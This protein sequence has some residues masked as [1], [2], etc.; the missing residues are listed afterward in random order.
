MG[1]RMKKIVMVVIGLILGALCPVLPQVGTELVDFNHCNIDAASQLPDSFSIASEPPSCATLETSRKEYQEG[2]PVDI[3]FTNGCQTSIHLDTSPSWTIKDKDGN[4]ICDDPTVIFIVTEIRPSEEKTWMWYQK[5][6]IGK[7]VGLGTYTFFLYAREGTYT[8]TFEIIPAPPQCAMVTTNQEAYQLGEPVEI[9]FTNNC[10][11]SLRY[12]NEPPWVVKDRQGQVVFPEFVF[13]PIV[14]VPPGEQVTWTWDQKNKNQEQVPPD[15]YSIELRTEE[16][17]YKTTFEIVQFL[18]CS[19]LETS[20]K[21]YQKGEPVEILFTNNCDAFINLPSDPPWVISDTQGNIVFPLNVLPVEINIP[22]DGQK[23]WTWDQKNNAKIPKQVSAGTYNV[24]LTSLEGAYYKTTFKIVESLDC[25]VLETDKKIYQVGVP[26]EILFTNNCQTT[27]SLPSEPP[28]VITD[29]HGDIVFPAAVLYMIVEVSPGEQKMWTWNQKDT[30][31]KQ[32]SAGTYTIELTSTEGAYYRTTFEIVEASDCAL[33]ETGTKVYQKGVPVEILFTNNCQAIINLPSDP[34]WVISDS[35]G[36]VVYPGTVL[37]VLVEVQPGG[38][39]TW[40]WDQKTKDKVPKQVPAGTYTIELTSVEGVYYR[41]TFEIAESFAPPPGDMVAVN[42][43]EYQAGES[44]EILFTN[45][46][47]EIIRFHTDPP[48]VIKDS[49]GHI[50]LPHSVQNVIVE[51]Q[52][53][54]QR[55]WT[56]DQKDEDGNQVPPGTY[57]VEFSTIEETAYAT[58]FDI[59][60]KEGGFDGYFLLIFSLVVVIFWRL[61]Q[62]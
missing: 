1:D 57:T 33:L 6:E 3:L 58:T 21:V 41:T 4:K 55:K 18:N 51:V 43:E 12:I 23:T 5:N 52:P 60:E 61:R 20:K 2:E 30:H 22:P 54:E 25:A 11:T 8:T 44:V 32:V 38:Q 19:T 31:Q 7:Q 46:S 59:E 53:G 47:Q 27:I 29:S 50:I 45:D 13:F 14:E 9:L 16:G 62:K 24:E 35:S 10:Q 40:T 34:P 26:V 48:W 37:T 39:E 17:I 56:W 15:T 49:Q 28:W 36:N 42:Q